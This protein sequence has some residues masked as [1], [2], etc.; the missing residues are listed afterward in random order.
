MLVY[1]KE[2]MGYAVLDGHRIY[3]KYY[4]RGCFGP[5]S[6]S[7]D[8]Y[9]KHKEQLEQFEITSQWLSRKFKKE[10]PNLSFTPTSF[11]T[12]DFYSVIELARLLGID[13]KWNGRK[14]FTDTEKRALRRAVL[15]RIEEQYESECAK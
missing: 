9:F 11:W 13:Y 3:G 10:F 7:R 12:I 8:F 2:P 1:L 14:D 15:A 6:V 4:S 5:R